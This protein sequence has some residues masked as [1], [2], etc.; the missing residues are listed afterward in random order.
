MKKNILSV[1]SFLIAL[2]GCVKKEPSPVPNAKSPEEVVRTFVRLSGEAKEVTDKSKLSDLCT[3][4]MKNALI[5]INDEQFRLFYLSGNVNIQELKIL[6]TN[7][8]QA[9]AT[10]VYQVLVENRQGTDITKELN[11]REAVLGEGPNG[12]LIESIR[13]RGTDKLIFSRGMVF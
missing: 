6:S 3:G 1:M 4:D 10:I 5:E 12:W 13:P 11:E 2:N 9:K 7:I 8:S